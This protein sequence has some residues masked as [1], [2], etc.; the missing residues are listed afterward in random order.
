MQAISILMFMLFQSG[1]PFYG[2][3]AG[4][5]RYA[6]AA[7]INRTNVAGLKVAWTYRTGD[8]SDGS[9][10]MRKSKFETTPILFNGMLYI[11][12]PFNRVIALD[13]ATG[14]PRWTFDPRIDLKTRYSESLVSRGVSSWEDTQAPE[15]AACKRRIFLATLDARLIAIDAGNGRPCQGFG[16]SSEVDLKQGVGSIEAGQ[17][18]ITSP[19]AIINDIV[20]VGSSIGDNRRVDLERGIVRAF[21]ARSGQ[22][23]WSWDPIPR[24]AASPGYDTWTP[25]GAAKTGAANAWSMISADAARDLVFVPTG[26]AS[27]DFYGGERPGSNL[28]A[29]SV[30]AIRASS[31]RVAWHFQVV[32]HDLWDY[33]VASQPLLTT[34]KRSGRDVPAVVVNTKMGH[35]FVLHRETGEPLFPVEERPVPRSDVPGETAHPT[36]PFPVLPP[37]LHP[38]TLSVD[39][40]SDEAERKSC[41]EQIDA[42]R[43]EGIFTP[44]SLK[45]TVIY[46][47]YAG[48]VNWGSAAA[49]A[50][51][52]LMVVNVNQI[53]F[54]VR[55]IPR[56]QFVQKRTEASRV[57]L[58]AEFTAQGGT[59]YGMSRAL[60]RSS[61]GNPCV[62]RP[63]GKT[64]A[65]DLNTGEIKWETPA[66]TFSFGGAI[67][68]GGGLVFVSGGLD[69]RLR[70][71]DI[72]SGKE[73]WSA[74]LPAGAQSTPMSYQL[75]N[76]KQMV[77]IAAGGNGDLPVALG[78]YVIA[79]ALP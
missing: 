60:I 3:D 39:Q 44:P 11:S 51:R 8:V 7:E 10:G 71:L 45:G 42:L 63:W 49:D 9:D 64:V 35:V 32:H 62:P 31:G 27:P 79:Y 73:L 14:S 55:L 68:T 30:V 18:A 67:I 58:D 74:E 65:V 52:G 20:V 37:P 13:P 23:K 33:D 1:W 40:I 77:V 47:G 59:P 22:M 5:S 16:R 17:Y 41:K 53:A 34:V 48:G 4:G 72:T 75:P 50:G 66:P 56:D 21:D 76:G 25:E 19:P 24:N 70:G 6:P 28:Y 43:S 26:S 38:H 69:Q 12:T 61:K 36:Q 54:W 2:G 46:P 78:D 15:G 29:N 57:Q